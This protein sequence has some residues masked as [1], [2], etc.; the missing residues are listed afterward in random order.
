VLYLDADLL[1]EKSTPLTPLSHVKSHVRGEIAE[2][3][4]ELSVLDVD[5]PREIR[6]KS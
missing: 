5:P 6:K 3:D 1:K 2:K 4:G